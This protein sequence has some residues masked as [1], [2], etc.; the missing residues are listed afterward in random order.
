M[1]HLIYW[2][3]GPAYMKKTCPGKKGDPPAQPSQLWRV[4]I[5]MRRK[6]TPLLE[7]T[8]IALIA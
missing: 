5:R 8:A 4:F 2:I 3:L 1:I 7:L 6:S